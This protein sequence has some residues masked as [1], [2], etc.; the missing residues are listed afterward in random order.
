MNW[1]ISS[2]FSCDERI[3]HIKVQKKKEETEATIPV[4]VLSVNDEW[5]FNR[6]LNRR[7]WHFMHF[8]ISIEN[9]SDCVRV[10]KMNG[11]DVD[12]NFM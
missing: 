11:N 6:W 12:D 1:L 8:I 7:K 10:R 5:Q 9:A 2:T 3:H 4:Y